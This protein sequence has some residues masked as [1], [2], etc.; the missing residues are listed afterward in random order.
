M[1][2]CLKKLWYIH[3]IYIYEALTLCQVLYLHL[4][5]VINLPMVTGLNNY[6]L[7]FEHRQAKYNLVN[8]SQHKHDLIFIENNERRNLFIY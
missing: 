1:T 4:G 3:T 6:E 7:Q 8:N 5:R 2:I